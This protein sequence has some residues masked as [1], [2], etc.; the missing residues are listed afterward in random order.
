MST[1]SEE[2]KD[3]TRTVPKAIMIATVVSGLIFFGLS[4]VSQL[5]FPSNQFADVDCGCDWTS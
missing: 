5:V 4:Y 1:L 2:A 3:P